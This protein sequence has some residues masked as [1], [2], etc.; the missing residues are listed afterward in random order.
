MDLRETKKYLRQIKWLGGI[1]NSKTEQLKDLRN[2]AYSISGNEADERVQ[3]SMKLDKIGGVI[4]KIVDL[5]NELN[6]RIDEFVD[7]KAEVTAKIDAVP[8]TDCRLLLMLRYLNFKT[9]EEIAEEMNY[10]YQWVHKIHNKALKSLQ[11]FI[12]VD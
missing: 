12:K 9:W 10:S 6:K 4:S 5:E 3:T 1:I 8:D 2:T 11:K 7:L